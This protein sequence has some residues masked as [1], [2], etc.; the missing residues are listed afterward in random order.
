MCAPSGPTTCPQLQPPIRELQALH[1][2]PPARSKGST[3]S[4]AAGESSKIHQR[5]P[6]PERGRPARCCWF[7]PRPRG[8]A[9]R[10]SAGPQR[11]LPPPGGTGR[12]T[13]FPSMPR[14]ARR[15]IGSAEP[16]DYNSRRAAGRGCS[17]AYRPPR[18]P[19]GGAF[20]GGP[21][22]GPQTPPEQPRP[23]LG[24]RRARAAQGE[25]PGGR[26][27]RGGRA[28]GPAQAVG[29]RTDNGGFISTDFR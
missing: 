21:A 7:R 19:H 20:P 9:S 23:P 17:E 8:A 13:T 26:G 10:G 29:T 25:H 24:A 15:P 6:N 18:P 12:E 3:G 16:K 22:G 5:G 4:K 11:R 28:G 1:T 2:R 27:G 14:T